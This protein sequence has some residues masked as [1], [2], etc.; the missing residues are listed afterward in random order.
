MADHGIKL[1][2]IQCVG[3]HLSS[4]DSQHQCSHFDPVQ[5]QIVKQNKDLIVLH[6]DASLLGL[7]TTW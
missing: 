5:L 4:V 2:G 3:D 7:R 1:G 6:I